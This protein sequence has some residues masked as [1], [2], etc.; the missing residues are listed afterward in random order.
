MNWL[1]LGTSRDADRFAE[2][3]SQGVGEG[4]VAEVVDPPHTLEAVGRER[5]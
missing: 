4:K 5:T 2:G 1:L 3:G